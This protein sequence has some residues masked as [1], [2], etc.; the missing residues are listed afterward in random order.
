VT[1]YSGD[2]RKDEETSRKRIRNPRGKSLDTLTDK[3]RGKRVAGSRLQGREWALIIWPV[4][5]EKAISA[6]LT[7]CKKG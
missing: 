3:K 7:N 4:V 5:W 2:Y 6:I 1:P